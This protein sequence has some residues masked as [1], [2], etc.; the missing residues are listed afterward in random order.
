MSR[1][2]PPPPPKAGRAAAF[3]TLVIAMII[4][5]IFIGRN[6]WHGEELHDNQEVGDNVASNYQG[7]PNY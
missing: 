7:Q 2:D 3:I 1:I 4:A 5:I 6:V